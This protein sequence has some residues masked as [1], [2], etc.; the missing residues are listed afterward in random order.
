MAR[1]I[2]QDVFIQLWEKRENIDLSKSVKTYISTSVRNK[3][4]NYLRDHQK[5]NTEILNYEGLGIDS[6]YEVTDTL[7]EKDLQIQISLAINELP[8]KCR[9]VFLLSREKELKYQEIATHLGISVKTVETQMSK[10][11]QH[12]RNR[13]SEYIPLLALMMITIFR[14][15]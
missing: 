5:F 6:G 4:L 3:C 9:E 1:E 12:L 7:I 8:E 2:V 14:S 10:A 15:K 11:L 13:L